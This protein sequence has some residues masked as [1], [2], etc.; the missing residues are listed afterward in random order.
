MQNLA[1]IDLAYLPIEEAAFAQNPFPHF[2]AARERHPWLAKCSFG[3]L[4]TD[5]DAIRELI[6]HEEHMMMGHNAVTELMGARHTPWGEF[7]AGSIQAQYG[8]THKR[9]KTAILPAFTPRQANAY[10]PV[11]RA[12]ISQLL[13]EWTPKGAFDFEEFAAFFP[14]SVMCRMLG[15]SPTIIPQIRDALEALGLA[16]SMDRKYLPALQNGVTMMEEFVRQ[17]IADRR[18]GLRL[19]PETDLLDLL[20]QI[21]EQGGLSEDE[22][23]NL[24]IFLFAAG[25][26]TSKNVLT[27]IMHALLDRPADYARCATDPDF[28]RKVMDESMRCF[29]PSAGTRILADDIVIR[30]VLLPKGTMIMI[31]WSVSGR[32]P[33]VVDEPD[34]FNPERPTGNPHMAF[35]RG[36]KICLGQFIARAQIEEGLHLIAQRIKNP[37]RAGAP[38]WR[39]FPGVW[40]IHGLPITFDPAVAP[41]PVAA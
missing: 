12:V 41:Q 31:P 8:E 3:Y 33:G 21:R 1:D 16:F 38:G 34:V 5:W 24:V 17:H 30:E 25:Y 11:M 26:D 13:D 9:L 39:P 20:L 6:A 27:L 37:R 7:V 18:M 2:V 28:C 35:G 23:S 14:I 15:T 19:S 40:G 4:I 36:P 22:L 29:N 10:R 32:A